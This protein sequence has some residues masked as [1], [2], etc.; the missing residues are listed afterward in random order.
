M[1]DARKR[2]GIPEGRRV[3]VA[4][5]GSLGARTIN[6]ALADLRVRW[7]ARSDVALVHVTGRRDWPELT[8]GRPTESDGPGLWFRLIEFEDRMADL[9]SVADVFVCRAG[10]MTV[11]ELA[12]TGVAS[13]LVPLP[14]A[15]SDHQTA[16]ARALVD[17]GGAVLLEDPECRG[18]RVD[19]IL[20]DMVAD[21]AHLASMGQAAH[22]LGRRDAAARIAELVERHAG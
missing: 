21:P 9:Y 13:V 8:A 16:N 4:F 17:A 14:G 2:L 1:T 6:Q 15:P 12:V 3:V 20:S 18:G 7:S 5:G 22:R 11:G 10:A 19:E